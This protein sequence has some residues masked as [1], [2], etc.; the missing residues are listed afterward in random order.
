[1]WKDEL[2]ALFREYVSRKQRQNILDYDDLLLYLYYLLQDEEA[3]DSV[4]GRFDHVLVDEYQDTNRIQAGILMGLRHKNDN[5]MVVG[6]D[7]QSI[8]SFRSATVHN[9]LDFPQQYP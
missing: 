8:Y 2:K 6:D 7:A 4:G 9:M 1:M 5:I 3:A